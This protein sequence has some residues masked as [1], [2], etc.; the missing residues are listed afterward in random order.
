[1]SI[2]NY[3][4]F[5]KLYFNHIGDL[6]FDNIPG[7]YK[8]TRKMRMP[9][10]IL[11][12]IM[13]ISSF[14]C[15]FFGHREIYRFSALVLIAISIVY[16]FACRFSFIYY[17]IAYIRFNNKYDSINDSVIFNHAVMDS[18][19]S[20]LTKMVSKY[21]NFYVTSGNVFAVKISLIAK[22]KKRRKETNHIKRILKITPNKI[23]LN[24]K[25]IF[26]NKLLD[27]SDLEKIL[28]D[29]ALN[30]TI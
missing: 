28:Y 9:F 16:L 13:M 18:G 1:M 25:L 19:E 4:I 12:Y 22:G 24:R 14:L 20:E 30:K 27:M 23:Y 11:S 10:I 6:H 15:F 3:L 5:L 17:F 29:E 21:F 2:K 8:I 26:D 7:R